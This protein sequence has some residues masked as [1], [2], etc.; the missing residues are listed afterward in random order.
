MEFYKEYIDIRKYND[1]GR[2]FR[3]I[4]ATDQLNQEVKINQQWKSEVK[5]Y[6][7]EDCYTSILV[8][9][10]GLSSTDFTEVHYE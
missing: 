5:G 1:N 6:M 4:T 8:R 7:V 3:T 9:W 10:V 2:S